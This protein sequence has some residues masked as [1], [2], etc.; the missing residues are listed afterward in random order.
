MTCCKR[1]QQAVSSDPSKALR[2]VSKIKNI[3]VEKQA[4][5]INLQ[6]TKEEI[7]MAEY[8]TY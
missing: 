4:R 8:V 3:L 1:N 2:F 7:Q 5:N 6:F